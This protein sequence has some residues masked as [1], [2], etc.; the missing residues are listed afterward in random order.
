MSREGND[1]WGGKLKGAGG[2]ERVIS[3]DRVKERGT[4]V[5]G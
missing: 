4:E 2:G 3:F 1:S 5:T